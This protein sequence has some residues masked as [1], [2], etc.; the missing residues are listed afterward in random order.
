MEAEENRAGLENKI[1]KAEEDYNTN[2]EKAA[3]ATQE[4][5]DAIGQNLGKVGAVITGLGI[6]MSTIGG[7]LSEMGLEEAGETLAEIGN[8]VT[9]LGGAFMALIPVIQFVGT[10]FT[11]EG[12]K[13]AI[14]GTTAQLAWWWVLLIVV[15]VVALIAA[16]A[17]AIN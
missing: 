3:S 4:K 15:A 14:A 10:T 8:V 1:A 11:I 9:L 17:I 16:T 12:G 13:I 6:G 5:W 7:I 2:S